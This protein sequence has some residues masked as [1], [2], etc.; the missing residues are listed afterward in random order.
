MDARWHTIT[1]VA[2]SLRPS[3]KRHCGAM[4][5]AVS[6]AA[7]GTRSN[8]IIAADRI[9]RCL[10][11]N[12]VKWDCFVWLTD[13]NCGKASPLLRSSLDLGRI[14]AATLRSKQSRLGNTVFNTR[15]RRADERVG[16][17]TEITQELPNSP[18]LQFGSWNELTSHG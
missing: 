8:F 7:L 9:R 14:P 18:V 16:C 3:A 5:I 17:A 13:L 11:T 15:V 12:H 2:D 4:S 6:G 10:I 1:A